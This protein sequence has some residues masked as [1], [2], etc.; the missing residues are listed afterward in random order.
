MQY[1]YKKFAMDIIE[2]MM[3]NNAEKQL[4][5]KING[6][7]TSTRSKPCETMANRAVSV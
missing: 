6:Q 2:N 5:G 4:A 7:Y 1:F 3:Y